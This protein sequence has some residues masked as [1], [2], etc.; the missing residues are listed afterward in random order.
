MEEVFIGLGSN[1]GDREGHLE[2]AI[3]MIKGKIGEVLSFS[4]IYETEP[5]GFSSDDNFLNMVVR[6]KTGH[7]AVRLIN[8]ILKVEKGLGRTRS[9][10]QYE[11]RIIDIDILLY[12]DKI[13]KH[14]GLTIPH[15]LIQERKFVLVPLCDLYQ[16]GIH[17][18][19]KKS[20]LTLYEECTDKCEVTLYKRM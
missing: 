17:P 13:I 14:S 8:E 2:D 4:N 11:S 7:G 19:L 6:I 1:I 12:G 5:W 3:G 15:P 9:G 18:V 20:F 10:A 16:D